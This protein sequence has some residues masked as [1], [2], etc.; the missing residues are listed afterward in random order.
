MQLILFFSRRISL[1]KWFESGMAER[2][3][4]LYR[5]HAKKGISSTF[6]T[7]DRHISPEIL[8]GIPGIKILWNRL[9][10]HDTLYQF[11]IPVLHATAFIKA[12]VLKTNQS[13][14]SRPAVIASKIFNKPLLAR[15]GYLQ[16]ELIISSRGI[17]APKTKRLIRE[18]NNLFSNADAIIVTTDA[19]KRNIVSRLPG[20]ASK[21]N[22]LPNYVDTDLFTPA[23]IVKKYDIIYV[24][25][26]SSEKNLDA[27]LTASVRQRCRTLII[28]SGAE[29]INLKE[30]HPSEL[31]EWKGTIP[32]NELP[33][34]INRSRIFM[35]TSHHE[36]NPKVLLEAMACGSAIIGADS[37]G[38]RDII[39]HGNTGILSAGDAESLSVA[40]AGIIHDP[41]RQN[42][43]GK[44]ARAFALSNYSLRSISEKEYAII[45]SLKGNTCKRKIYN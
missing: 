3:S 29:A 42:Y 23:E 5:Q 9:K 30:R 7:Y 8:P 4:A 24:G 28:G 33:I 22:V 13:S 1:R 39:R 41:E 2:E 32:N 18:E 20:T 37:P 27:L 35:L 21:I 11:L 12:D 10:L 43:F 26:L 36:G 45:E 25:R 17:N 16:S 40:I 34:W 38:I 44:N 31:I 15:C 14:G 19:M 6:V